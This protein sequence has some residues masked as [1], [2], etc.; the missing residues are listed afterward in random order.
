MP[1]SRDLTTAALMLAGVIA[2]HLMGDKIIL[3]L[4]DV[5]RAL[6]GSTHWGSAQDMLDDS[7]RV[8]LRPMISVV[9]PIMAVLFVAAF[10]AVFYQN[11]FHIDFKP[12]KINF[13]A[14]N[15]MGGFK[16]LFAGQN[17][18]MMGMN[19]VKLIVVGSL[20]VVRITQFF[21]RIMMLGRL[22]FPA[23]FFAALGMIYDLSL[24][25]TVVLLVLSF[26]DW[27]YQKWNF[28]KNIR[29]TKQEVK[30]EAKMMEGDMG[31]KS[32][33]RAMGRKM[34]LQRVRTAVPKADVVITNPTHLAIALRYDPNTMNAPVVV[35]KGADNLAMTIRQIALQH[36]IPI[37]ERKPLAQAMYKS[38]EPGQ[39]VPSQF[40]QAIAEILAYVYEIS[41][42]SRKMRKSA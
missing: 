23:N 6:L 40:Y 5:M 17:M 13:G 11:N 1:R 3:S 33:R 14:L 38:V 7:L 15:M 19:M 4:A 29:M 34:I 26:L 10:A 35:A 36:N 31:M 37:I 42:K 21:P 12:P 16:R 30:D 8:G 41:G 24:K 2:I 32:K 28:E 25:V 39:E 27:L 22:G 20:V 9:L 18:F